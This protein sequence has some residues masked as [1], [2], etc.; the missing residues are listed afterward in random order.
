MIMATEKI[1]IEK[2]VEPSTGI[3]HLMDPTVSG[4][5]YTFCGIAWD[6]PAT[7]HRGEAMVDTKLPINCEECLRN[8]RILKNYTTRALKKP[9]EKKKSIRE[10]EPF[11]RPGENIGLDLMAIK[12]EE[13]LEMEF[14]KAYN[15]DYEYEWWFEG[16]EDE[17]N[18]YLNEW[19]RL[20]GVED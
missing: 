10:H 18:R 20:H 8:A 9:P 11:L 16:Y 7:E 12:N 1:K 14:A 13:E 5:E 15:L 3:V 2:M 6:E 17:L 19:R 4:G